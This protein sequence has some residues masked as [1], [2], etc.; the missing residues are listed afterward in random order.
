MVLTT[1]R[2]ARPQAQASLHGQARPGTPR[3]RA[4]VSGGAL[5]SALLAAGGLV[6][7]AQAETRPPPSGF[8]CCNLRVVSDW[9]SDIN[10]RPSGA[11]VVPAGTPV[12]GTEWARY[13]IGLRSGSS[14]WWLGNDYSRDLDDRAFAAR[15]IVRE[16]PRQRIR[17]ADPFAQDAIR[18]SR[19]LYGMHE[20]EVAMALGYPVASYTP[21]L[22][23]STWKYW[24]DRTGEFSVRFDERRRVVGVSGD[25]RVLA[26][27]LYSPSAAVIRDAQEMLSDYGHPLGQPD[28][29]MGPALRKALMTFQQDNSLPQTGRL[30]LATLR[31]LDLNPR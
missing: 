11:S 14:T 18:R 25:A 12:R 20:T 30:D 31:R 13:S 17:Q 22:G 16:D 21:K 5:I 6:A 9:I 28:G 24:I 19:V 3:I 26:E 2:Q 8:L 29:R 27:V 1:P 15:Y 4:S 23:L 10:Y 7:S